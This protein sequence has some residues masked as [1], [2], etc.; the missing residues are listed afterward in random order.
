MVVRALGNTGDKSA[1]PVLLDRVTSVDG[2]V[3]N[4]ICGA[5][6]QLTHY[7]WCDGN[8]AAE[9]QARWR[10]FWASNGPTMKIYPADKCV[11]LAGLPFIK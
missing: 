6:I 2:S 11:E 10:R 4:E 5:L 8:P 1:V 9:M 7:Q 3:R